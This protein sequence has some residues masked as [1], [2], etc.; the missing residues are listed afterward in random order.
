MKLY[1]TKNSKIGSVL[2]RWGTEGDCSHFAVC[3]DDCVV[4]QATM[5]QGVHLTSLN[6]F[7]AKNEVVHMLEFNLPLEMEES[8]WK[9]LVRRLAGIYEYDFKAFLYWTLM[10]IRHRIF[11]SLIPKTNLWGQA[12]KYMCVEVASELPDFLFGGEKI[13]GLDI[14]SPQTLFHVIDAKT[15]SSEYRAKGNL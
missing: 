8:T 12:K 6:E 13:E 11:G 1:W 2:I 3:F 10:V 7:L 5:N 9:P 15:Q 4:L 14:M